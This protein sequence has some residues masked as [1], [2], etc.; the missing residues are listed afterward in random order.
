MIAAGNKKL[1]SS[2]I[3]GIAVGAV[4]IRLVLLVI[5]YCLIPKKKMHVPIEAVV[6]H[7]PSGMDMY[8]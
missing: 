2:K 6:N 8:I 7:I 3:A 5:I 4:A 1:S